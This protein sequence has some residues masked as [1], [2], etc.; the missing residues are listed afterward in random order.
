MKEVIKEI[1]SWTN[2]N[3]PAG[4]RQITWNGTDRNGKR[5]PA[6]IYISRLIARSNISKRTF[7][8]SR[9]LVLL[10]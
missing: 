2:H 7:S 3:E 9:K 8:Q 1:S 10:K 6:G 5:V 4:Y